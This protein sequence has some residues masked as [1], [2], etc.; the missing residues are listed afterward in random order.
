M[1]QG[2]PH[3]RLR[4]LGGLLAVAVLTTTFTACNTSPRSVRAAV[5][6][7]K[8]RKKAPDF[9]LRDSDGKNVKLSE[10]KG[11]VVLLNFWATWCGPCKI[12]IPWFI[13]FEQQYKDKGFAVLG[14]SMD[15]EGWN[16]VKPYIAARKI[17]YRVLLGDDSVSNLYGG[18]ES[19]PTTFILDR[20]GRVAS[21]HIG[22]VGKSDYQNEIIHLLAGSPAGAGITADSSGQ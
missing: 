4:A 6:P 1:D 15:E 8:E 9:T 14:V 7:E 22:L 19:L 20:D 21:V 11:K 5:K 2:E 10:Y 13:D 17:N 12:E 18:V 3:L 16:A